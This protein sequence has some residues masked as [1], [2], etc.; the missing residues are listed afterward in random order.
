MTSLFT[1]FLNNL[2]PI[3]LIAGIGYAIGKVF[4]IEAKHLS[5]V[6]FYVL[7]PALVFE[8]LTNSALSGQEMLR[9]VGLAALTMVTCGLLA[10]GFSQWFHLDR[11]MTA[12]LVL[13]SGLINA[14]NYGMSLNHFAFGEDALA[15]ASLFYVTSAIL[16]HTVGVTVASMGEKSFW[17][18]V[19]GLAKIPTV[20]AVVISIVFI[21]FHWHLPL[22][23]RRVT[24]YLADAAIPMMIILLGLQ[25]INNHGV[26]FPKA[27]ITAVGIRLL[28]SPLLALGYNQI[29]L[30]DGIAFKA[31]ILEAAMP[32]AVI[33]TVIA[34]EFEVAPRFITSVVFISTLL[35]PF[36]LTPLLSLLGA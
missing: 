4:N 31:A 32:T 2:F 22:P 18:S 3:L 30:L 20:Y 17:A 14:G 24:S 8:S 29:F 1:L 23:I 19:K 9:M 16:A 34:T 25:L 28:V 21:Y 7:S 5:R 10:Y 11:K 35:S 27:L 33:S 15:Q 13:A 6:I 26:V 36:T 12:A